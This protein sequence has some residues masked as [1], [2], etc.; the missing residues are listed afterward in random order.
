MKYRYRVAIL[1]FALSVITYLDRVCISVAGPRIQEYLRIGPEEWGWVVGVFAISYGAFEIPGGWM[2]DRFGPRI[3]LTRIVLWWSAFTALTGAVST[4]PALLL[5]RFSFG[6]GEAGAFP[7]ATASI[8]SWFPTG[9]RGRAFGVLSV[10]MQVGGALSPVLVI[11]IQTRYGWRASFYAFAL[12][13][14]AWAVVWFLWFRNTPREKRGVSASE[15]REIGDPAARQ[16]HGLPWPVALVSANFWAILLMGF[17]YGYGSYFFFTWLPTYLVRARNFTEKELLFTAFLFF[18]GAC[19]NVGSGVISDLLL[20]HAGLRAARCR[21][22]M[23]GFACAAIFV[24]LAAVTPSRLATLFL[25]CMSYAGV[26]FT[27][28]MIFPTCIEVARTFPG[29]MAG[30]QNTTSQVGSFLS[31]VLFGYIAKFSGSY[32]RPLFLLASVLALGALFWLKINPE[33]E[34]VPEGRPELTQA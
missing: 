9:E 15:L 7:N 21:I 1:L 3:V 34:L 10:A 22:G 29:S 31:G 18:F 26:C 16:R 23:A 28:P 32:D 6:A 13:G 17:C 25:L 27:E 20:K 8:A 24:L 19:A 33:R 12:L 30:A 2:A 14:L 4:Y 5:T 11:P